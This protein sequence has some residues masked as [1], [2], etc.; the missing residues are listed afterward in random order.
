MSNT[1]KSNS[2]CNSA[3]ST[4]YNRLLYAA[5]L[6]EL[7]AISDYIYYSLIS[8]DVFPSVSEMFEKIA[9]DEMHHFRT[10]GR[11]MIDLGANPSI[12]TSIRSKNLKYSPCAGNCIKNMSVMQ[13]IENSIRDEKATVKQYE[14]VLRAL[15]DEKSKDIISKIVADEEKHIRMLSGVK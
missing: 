5:Y 15:P 9:M 6:S 3:D 4:P 7:E 1:S 12:L 2:C 11:L 14:S 10:L 13:A 8:E